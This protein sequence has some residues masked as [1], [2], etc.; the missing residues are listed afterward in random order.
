[1]IARLLCWLRT[2][3]KPMLIGNDPRGGR[4]YQRFTCSDCGAEWHEPW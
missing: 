1:M 2:G 3:H 4:L